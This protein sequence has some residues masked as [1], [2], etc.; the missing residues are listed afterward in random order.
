M[1]DNRTIKMV[2]RDLKYYPDWVIKIECNA[3]LHKGMGYSELKSSGGS[4]KSSVVEKEYE[5]LM[6]LKSKVMIIERVME[7]LQGRTKNIIEERYFL[8]YGRE[9]I[10]DNNHI[11]KKQYYNLRNR[12]FESFAR[13]LGYID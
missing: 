1:I 3:A 9:Q 5:A 11:S 8:E 13:S 12:A 4:G 10:L 7:R 2:E 6:R